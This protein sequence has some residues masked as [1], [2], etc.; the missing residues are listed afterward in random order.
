[1]VTTTGWVQRLKQIGSRLE[2]TISTSD[3]KVFF[4]DFSTGNAGARASKLAIGN[5]L[6][7]AFDRG[8][9]VSIEHASGHEEIRAVDVKPHDVVQWLDSHPAIA[10]AVKW[11]HDSAGNAYEVAESAKTPWVKWTPEMRNDLASA[12][13]SAWDWLHS[14]NPLNALQETLVYPPDNVDPEV[15]DD[16]SD[17]SV[18]VSKTYA[19]DLYI[20]WL[21]HSLLVEI[22]KLVPWS[23]S[24]ASGAQRQAILDSASMMAMKPGDPSPFVLCGNPGHPN[25]VHRKDN[26]GASLI[27]PPRYTYAFLSKTG[28]IGATRL[29]TIGNVLNWARDNLTHFFGS[30]T[31]LNTELHWQYRGWPPVTRI[32]EGTTHTDLNE[33]RHWTAGCHG[34]FAFIR[35]LLRAVNIPVQCHRICGHA[36]IWFMTEDLY[37]DHGDDPY[38]LTFKATGLP[39]S[40][41]LIDAAAFV[42]LFGT[43]TDNH[44]NNC[45]NVSHSVKVLSP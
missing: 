25:Y 5:L 33:F 13:K 14:V 40:A 31:Y 45:E 29:D 36:T 18:L 22:E 32:I 9:A 21:A 24:E 27:G 19:W 23:L 1:M 7:R 34:T 30:S 26:L 37:I 15:A 4:V 44:E 17:P 43:E 28:L 12:Y 11:Q 38:N 2:V 10:K 6:A 42:A 16:E 41:L 39:A 8:Q 35:H 20:R 3:E